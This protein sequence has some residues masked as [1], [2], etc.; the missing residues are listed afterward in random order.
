MNQDLL[1]NMAKCNQA[2]NNDYSELN[3]KKKI[4]KV[5]ERH[6]GLCSILCLV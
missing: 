5:K 2:Q 6:E 4:S 3:I 1:I